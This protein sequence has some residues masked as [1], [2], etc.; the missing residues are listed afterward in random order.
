MGIMCEASCL[1]QWAVKDAENA[2]L[3]Q[4][5]CQGS[6]MSTTTTH[7]NP[8]TPTFLL[9]STGPTLLLPLLLL[10]LPQTPLSPKT[11][12][13]KKKNTLLFPLSTSSF[14]SSVWPPLGTPNTF[15]HKTRNMHIICRFLSVLFGY[16]NFQRTRWFQFLKNISELETCY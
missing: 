6:E 13:N 3:T 12:T 5:A 10:T 7:H 14:M 4:F 11:K 15:Q 8:P 1:T 9:Q 16:W 2:K